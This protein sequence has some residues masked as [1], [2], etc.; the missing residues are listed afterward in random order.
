MHSILTITAAASSLAL[1]TTAELREA[2]GIGDNSQDTRLAAM[3]L[4]IAAAIMSECNIAVGAGGEPT[5]LRESVTETFRAVDGPILRLARRH[6][7][8]IASVVV[9]GSA[10]NG[11][12]YVVE[13]ES[14]LLA[15][16]SG[17]RA[18]RWCAGKVVVEYAAG[19]TAVPGDLKMA[20]MDFV[21][22]AWSASTRDPLVKG[23]ETDIIGVERR[24]T[25]YWVGSAPGTGGD[26]PV[27]DVVAG[28]L[29]RF[30]NY[31]TA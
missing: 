27:P 10:L 12:D 31:G 17:D 18:A 23:I 9:D 20:A 14:G 22:L 4:R 24:R 3:G 25:D 29:A 2:A 6:Q 19:F 13:P 7:I 15:R 26:G 30:R 16:M 28:Q 21:R 8:E 11:D 5:L 1:L